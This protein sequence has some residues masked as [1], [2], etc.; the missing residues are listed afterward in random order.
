M[1]FTIHNFHRQLGLH[2]F[3]LGVSSFILFGCNDDKDSFKEKDYYGIQFGAF[4]TGPEQLQTRANNNIFDITTEFYNCKYSIRMEG[5]DYDK[6]IQSNSGIYVIPSGYNAIIVPDN[7]QIPLNWF[8]R[9]GQHDFWSW[10]MPHDS[11]FSPLEND[12]KIPLIIKDTN[13]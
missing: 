6:E 7:G 8:S 10:T 11:D 4:I 3:V 5:E 13:I 12:T 2:L 9:T 1:I